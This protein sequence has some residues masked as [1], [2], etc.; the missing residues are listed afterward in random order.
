MTLPGRRGEAFGRPAMGRGA[1]YADFDG[2]G[3]LDLALTALQGPARL[4]R[5]E[6]GNRNNWIRVRLAGTRSNRRG[7]GAVVRVTSA[8]GRQWRTV[9]SGSSYASQSELPLT[10][11]LG[12][13]AKVDTLEVTWPSGVTQRFTGVAANQRIVIDEAAGLRRSASGP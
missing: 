8:S 7:I 12:G 9:R 2:D 1:A 5:N 11:G 6:G 4:L 13:D 10:F 3:D